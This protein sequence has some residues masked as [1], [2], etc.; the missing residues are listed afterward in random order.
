MPSSVV[1]HMHYYPEVAVLRITFTSGDR[2]DYIKVPADVYEAMKKAPSKGEYLN[3]V[4]KPHYTYK[5]VT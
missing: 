2:Y 3:K 5:K 4:I 1:A